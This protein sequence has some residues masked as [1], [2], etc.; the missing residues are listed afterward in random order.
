MTCIF[1]KL[2]FS[3]YKSAYSYT[4]ND[5][6][7]VV[8][9]LEALVLDYLLFLFTSDIRDVSIIVAKSVRITSCTTFFR[10]HIFRVSNHSLCKF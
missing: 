5:S 9:V 1:N 6:P 7:L 3:L 8:H 10:L 4:M 2:I